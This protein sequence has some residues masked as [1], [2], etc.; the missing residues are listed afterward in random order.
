MRIA[1]CIGSIALCSMATAQDYRM[2]YP[3]KPLRYIVPFGAG[4]PTDTQAR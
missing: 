2:T 1:V 3:F 4:G